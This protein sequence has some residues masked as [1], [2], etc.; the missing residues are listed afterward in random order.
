MGV[1]YSPDIYDRFHREY[2]AMPMFASE[3]ASTLT[4][5]GEYTERL[6]QRVCDLLQPH[7]GFVEAGGRPVFCGGQLCL[8]RL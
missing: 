8:D 6:R 1:N 4:T 7:R 3:T 2:P 5:R